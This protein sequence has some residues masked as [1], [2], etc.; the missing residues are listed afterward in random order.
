MIRCS[1]QLSARVAHVTQSLCRSF[2]YGSAETLPVNLKTLCLATGKQYRD[3]RL[4]YSNVPRLQDCVYGACIFLKRLAA[5]HH[6]HKSVCRLV[7]SLALSLPLAHM[8]LHEA[9]TKCDSC[10]SPNAQSDGKDVGTVNSE[11]GRSPRLATGLVRP[12]M[13]FRT[14]LEPRSGDCLVD[15]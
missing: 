6:S 13:P 4:C 7:A 3:W 12:D 10:K 2:V 11:S 15:C 1:V 14:S 9:G 5:R 8:G